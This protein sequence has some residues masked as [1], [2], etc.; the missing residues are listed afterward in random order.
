MDQTNN[1]GGDE[2]SQP[3]FWQNAQ[4][5]LSAGEQAARLLQAPVFNLAYRQQMEDTVNQWLTSSPK[6]SNK[7]DSLYY[8]AK[9]L[10]Q[11]ATRMN[12][13]V[14]Q[15]QRV[16]VEQGADQDPKRKQA[17]YLDTQGFGIQ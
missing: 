16:L 12:G 17:D 7:R 2:T 3:D 5:I 14:E 11:M 4:E 13:F 1:S 8:Q 6:E 9:A 10:V 15:A